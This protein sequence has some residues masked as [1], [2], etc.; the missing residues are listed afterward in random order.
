MLRS[1]LLL[2]LLPLAA[3]AA[4][5]L[6]HDDL[7]GKW[8]SNWSAVD[9]EVNVL[10]VNDD[11]SSQYSRATVKAPDSLEYSWQSPEILF[12][13]DVAII[14]YRDDKNLVYKLVLAGWKSGTT[15][16]LF[17]HMYMYRDGHLFNGLPISLES[18]S[19]GD[20]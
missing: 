14:E 8:R 20:E 16:R 11:L 10:T 2:L 7:V 4:E 13:D 15:R 9:G 19:D 5:N 6:N 18:S 3:F 1:A 17:G 12:V